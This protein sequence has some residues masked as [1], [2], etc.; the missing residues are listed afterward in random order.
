[1][2]EQSESPIT[3]VNYKEFDFDKLVFDTPKKSKSGSY[4]SN[5]IYEGNDLYIQTPRLKCTSLIKT[6][7]RCAIDLEFDKSHGMFYDFITSID[8]YSIIQIQKN[9]KAW[10]S[11]EFPLDVVEE[12][13]KTPV[14]MGRKNKAPSLKIKV[15]MSKGEPTVTVY[16]NKNNLI[17]FDRMKE[18]TKTLIVM[19]FNGLKFLK[20]QVIC[21]WVPIQ[22]KSF[23]SFAQKRNVYLIRDNL[24]TDDEGEHSQKKKT[25]LVV[26]KVESNLP[27]NS[28][29]LEED[30]RE[31]S[32][33]KTLEVVLEEGSNENGSTQ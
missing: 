31:Q 24:L 28:L 22:I 32:K 25:G 20:Q 15:P 33:G 7:N 30:T 27:I 14:K 3:I 18:N 8:D 1:M 10:F 4:V 17:D 2:S 9:S 12:Y 26:E 6:D 21:E 19:R 11:K 29:E 23:Q 13:Y 16:D 5:G